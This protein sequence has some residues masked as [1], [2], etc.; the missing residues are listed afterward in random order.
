MDTYNWFFTKAT[1]MHARV[2]Y[3][4]TLGVLVALAVIHAGQINWLWFAVLF[5]YIDAIGTVP[6]TLADRASAD[7]LIPRAYYL[8]YNVMHSGVTQAAVLAGLWLAIG[9]HWTYLA[10]PI[11]LCL[12]RGAFN[13]YLKP[14]RFRFVAERGPDFEKLQR[15]LAE[16]PARGSHHV[17]LGGQL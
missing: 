4:V 13:N 9:W 3:L 11:H 14:F 7:R 6:G 1:V 17:V 5:I 8:L 12:D 16:D 10:I 2:E 15:S